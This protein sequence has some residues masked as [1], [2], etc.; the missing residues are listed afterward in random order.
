MG[1]I[2]FSECGRSGSVIPKKSKVTASV[3]GMT[4]IQK[5]ALKSF[6]QSNIKP[7][8][9]KGPRK[10]PTVSNDWRNPKEAP[11]RCGGAISATNASR[12]APRTPLPILS[13]K[14]AVKTSPLL[15]AKANRGLVRA[16]NA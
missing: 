2:L 8:A 10:A 6:A 15:E 12:G 16:P 1:L 5:M 13:S 9:S 11:R 7:V 14:R 3:P 4:A